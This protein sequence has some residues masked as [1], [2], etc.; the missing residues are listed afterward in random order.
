MPATGPDGGNADGPG[1]EA[2]A[3]RDAG[4]AEGPKEIPEVIRD[5]RAQLS[6]LAPEEPDL[7]HQARRQ[8][9]EQP[10]LMGVPAVKA[11]A[12]RGLRG[13]MREVIQGRQPER[14]HR[15]TRLRVVFGKGAPGVRPPSS[16]VVHWSP[17]GVPIP[18]HVLHVHA[19]GAPG[20]HAGLAVLPNTIMPLGEACA[21]LGLTKALAPGAFSLNS[22]RGYGIGLHQSR[23]MVTTQKP[24]MHQSRPVDPV[25]GA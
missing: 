14:V 19:Q 7:A 16:G 22:R 11:S 1:L 4:H 9:S 10:C 21:P 6:G 12:A 5:V 8:G 15:A 23:I 24:I 13:G 20:L 2:L 3:F 17:D 18:S 25:L